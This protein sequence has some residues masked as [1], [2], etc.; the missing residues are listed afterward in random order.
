MNTKFT[1]TSFMA[2]RDYLT[3]IQSQQLLDQVESY[4]HGR[5][6][7][8]EMY[9]ITRT[10]CGGWCTSVDYSS[11]EDTLFSIAAYRQWDDKYL[12]LIGVGYVIAH[13]YGND[14]IV[15]ELCPSESPYQVGSGTQAMDCLELL[16]NATPTL[17]NT[18]LLDPGQ[19]APLPAP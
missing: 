14:P 8:D 5:V 6:R 10:E 12:V 2:Q 4:L 19:G 17:S 3:R 1:T 9:R 16:F 15:T 13:E 18:F 7:Q 11:D